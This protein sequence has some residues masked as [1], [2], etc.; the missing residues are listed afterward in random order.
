MNDPSA[1]D[2]GVVSAAN[3]AGRTVQVDTSLIIEQQKSEGEAAPVRAALS[4]Y[5]FRGSSTYARKEFKRAWLQDLALLNR[6]AKDSADIG[7]LLRRIETSVGLPAARRRRSRCVSAISAFLSAQSTG[8]ADLPLHVLMTR[9]RAHIREAVL[10]GF[11]AFERCI[12]HL[13]DGT[14]CVRSAER[15]SLA[16]DGSLDVVVRQCKRTSIKCTVHQFFMANREAFAKIEKHI[17]SLGDVASLELQKT[18]GTIRIAETDPQHLCASENCSAMSDALIA[19]DGLKMDDFA[20]NNPRE[21]TA[22]ASALGKPLV[23]PVADIRDKHDQ[24]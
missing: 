14:G 3:P 8:S 5:L 21:W 6:L 23:N 16:P 7:E 1:G 22:L 4:R 11:L 15:P 13:H 19:V 10:G 2:S 20:A 9:F 12:T 17:R 18:A 24:D